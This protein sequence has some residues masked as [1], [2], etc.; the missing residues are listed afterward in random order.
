MKTKRI[1]KGY[2]EL[3]KDGVKIE[4]NKNYDE[5]PDQDWIVTKDG[6]YL[7]TCITLK[8]AKDNFFKKGWYR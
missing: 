8:E 6:E 1:L 5:A 7:D 4:V 2:Y 3:E